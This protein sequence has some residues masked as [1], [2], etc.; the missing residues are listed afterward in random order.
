[1]GRIAFV[2]LATVL[3]AGSGRAEDP[4]AAAMR[5]R[6]EAA[7]TVRVGFHLKEFVAKGG[8]TAVIAA[9]P[10]MVSG[11]LP[12]ADTELESD[13]VLVLSGPKV[14][15]ENNHPLWNISTGKADRN[16]KVAV[17][18][19][20]LGGATYDNAE[21]G[22]A[23]PIGV[24]SRFAYAADINTYTFEPLLLHYRGVQPGL[25]RLLRD[26]LKA[27]GSYSLADGHNCSVYRAV[28]SEGYTVEV[29]ADPQAD[30]VVRRCRHV[31]QGRVTRQ[32]DIRYTPGGA[33]GWT[34]TD[35]TQ[36]EF[37]RDGR[38]ASV[39][40]GVVT[41]VAVNSTEADDLFELRFAPGVYV[42]DQRNSQNYRVRDDGFLQATTA[43]GKDLAAGPVAP[44]GAGWV[45]RNRWLLLVS[46]SVVATAVVAWWWLRRRRSV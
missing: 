7:K 23:T 14:R 43:D 6:Q 42:F 22:N 29:W 5:R 3:M 21:G 41:A 17:S 44:P 19:G 34:P 24:I 9:M 16:A 30:Y 40:T 39:A 36:S 46:G 4:L 11:A 32:T 28:L 18:D 31:K 13:N 27:T 12:P 2:A 33:A 38:V 10:G 15:A 35:W 8:V 26:G 37:A 45:V 20:R 1:M 25:S